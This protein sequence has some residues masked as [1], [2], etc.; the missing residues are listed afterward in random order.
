MLITLFDVKSGDGEGDLKFPLLV[1]NVHLYWDPSVPDFKVLQAYFA[2]IHMSVMMAKWF[3]WTAESIRS[4][5][6]YSSEV[7]SSVENNHESSYNVKCLSE[8]QLKAVLPDKTTDAT[9]DIDETEVVDRPLDRDCSKLPA[10]VLCGDFNSLPYLEQRPVRC[11]THVTRL[12]SS[13]GY[14]INTSLHRKTP[15]HQVYT[16]C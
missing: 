15:E 11:I 5:C 1:G 4:I 9:V 6:P 14:A 10:T 3:P 13:H 12:T 16:T 2:N 7:S 8:E